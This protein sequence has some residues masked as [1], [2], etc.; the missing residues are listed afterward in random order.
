M[1]KRG[2]GAQVKTKVPGV[3]KRGAR[4]IVG[5]WNPN[6]GENGGRDWVTV[7]SFEEAKRVKSEGDSKRQKRGRRPGQET[8]ASFA[9]RWTSE[10]SWKRPAESTNLHNAERIKPFVRDFGARKLGEVSRSEAHLW[11]WG[12][13]ASPDLEQVASGWNGVVRDADEAVIVPDH[14]G[15]LPAVRAMFSDAAGVDLIDGNPFSRL[16][17]PK[18]RGRRDM[19]DVLSKADL[20]L[21]LQAAVEE[22]GEVFGVEM[23]ALI[24]TAAWT[25]IRPGE[26]FALTPDRVDFQAREIRVLEQFNTKTGKVTPTKNKQRRTVV[27]LPEADQALRRVIRPSGPLFLTKRGKP[28]TGRSHHYYWDPIRTR[29]ASKLPASHWLS[30]RMAADPERGDLDFYELRHFFG[31]ALAEAGA[32]PDQIA[33]QMGHQDGGALAYRVYIHPNKER[34]RDDLRARFWGGEEAA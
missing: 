25:G 17:V 4:Y 33:D 5:I 6:K 26:L 11:V 7:D 13:I 8:V 23:Q 24:S 12:G 19:E 3:Y 32:R 18:T 22:Y 15:N 31:T 2:G 16:R 21:L 30:R 28:Y 20:E 14:R 9:K 27:L 29:F 10:E 34:L 1:A